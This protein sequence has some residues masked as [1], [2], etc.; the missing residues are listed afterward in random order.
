M[1]AL[2]R[3]QSCLCAQFAQHRQEPAQRFDRFGIDGPVFDFGCP[4]RHQLADR[5]HTTMHG[6]GNGLTRLA[7]LR[8]QCWFSPNK[9]HRAVGTDGNQRQRPD[10]LADRMRSAERGRALPTF[11]ARMLNA[12]HGP[13]GTEP[14]LK[15]HTL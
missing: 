8:K 5:A 15:H 11:E 7:E 10:Q 4:K 9:I 2:Q 14:T 1:P 6:G 12:C 3:E 13:I